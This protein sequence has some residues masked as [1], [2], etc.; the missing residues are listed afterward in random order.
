MPRVFL[1]IG[2]NEGD[3]FAAI[4]NAVQ[5]LSITP[6]IHVV[7]IAPIIETKPVGGPP[8]GDYLNTVVELETEKPPAELLALLKSIEKQLGRSPGGVRWGPRPIDLDILL[9]DD[10]I[11]RTPELDIPHPRFHERLFVL[12]PL[13]Q[14][15]PDLIHP[16]LGIPIHR[17][18]EQLGVRPQACGGVRPHG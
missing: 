17:L 18:A 10:A 3:R 8:Q 6:G 2:A 14:L 1:G 16:I 5:L 11:I 4:S 9:Y 15:A 13:A 7:Q 12:E